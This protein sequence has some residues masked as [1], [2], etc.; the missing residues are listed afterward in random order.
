MAKIGKAEAFYTG[1]GIW[2]SGMYVDERKYY[3]TDTW[4]M[5]GTMGLF[6]HLYDDDD[7]EYQGL[8]LIEDKTIDEMNADEKAIYDKLIAEL[9]AEKKRCGR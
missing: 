7:D 9:Q 2:V 6:D 1:G 3:M 8:Y 4:D 5:G